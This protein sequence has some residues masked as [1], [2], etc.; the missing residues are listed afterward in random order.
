MFKFSLATVLKVRKTEEKRQRTRYAQFLTART[1]IVAEIQSL[2]NGIDRLTEAQ[3]IKAESGIF[4]IH[5]FNLLK[6]RVEQTKQS[7]GETRQELE[8]FDVA[9]EAEKRKMAEAARRRK[10]IENLEEKERNLYLEEHRKTERKVVDDINSNRHRLK[11]PF[12]LS[13]E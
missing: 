12:V 7:L 4:A 6:S 10:I 9:F 13:H 5:D 8:R 3:Q 11:S 2:E 1:K